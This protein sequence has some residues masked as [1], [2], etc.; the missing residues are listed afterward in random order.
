MDAEKADAEKVV[1]EVEKDSEH[2]LVNL[3]VTLVGHIR[4]ERLM[5]SLVTEYVNDVDSVVQQLDYEAVSRLRRRLEIAYW[6]IRE[7]CLV[8]LTCV[9]VVAATLIS[10][11][12]E[13]SWDQKD[14][15]PSEGLPAEIRQGWA[16]ATRP[17]GSGKKCSA[18][19]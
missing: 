10:W 7:L 14:T 12:A 5:N 8:S 17:R 4:A 2:L 3:N 6:T 19:R 18:R 9:L 16:R 1:A 15:E 13:R 11:K